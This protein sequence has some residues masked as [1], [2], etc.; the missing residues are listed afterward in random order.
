MNLTLFKLFVIFGTGGIFFYIG[1][2]HSE[3]WVNKITGFCTSNVET[4]V[5]ELDYM[6]IE[7]TTK[8]VW[9][10]L[11]GQHIFFILLFTGLVATTVSWPFLLIGIPIGAAFGL[12]F[13]K[14]PAVFIRVLRKR[15]VTAFTG[16]MIDGLTLMANAMRSGLNTPQTLQLV[17]D[18]MPNPIAQEF[19]LVLSQNKV[20]TPLEEAF[21]NLAQ[22]IPSDEVEM[23]STSITILKET[24]GN[25][26]ETFDTIVSTIQSRL[27]LE[28]KIGA[29]V[30]QGLMQGI[31]IFCI[32]FVLG[33]V[34]YFMEP[35][36][37]KLMFT[38]PIGWVIIFVMLCMQLIG[39]FAILKIIDVKV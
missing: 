9:K 37:M 1:K 30:A 32:P 13:W 29:M 17:A 4:I 26:A 39:G 33:I 3:G 10:I 11:I 5:S 31:I 35:E 36:K 23:F 24:G 15:R 25:L 12:F 28:N 14:F 16:Q 7:V 27:K 8:R 20:G 6:F 18:E 2:K 38:T 34:F 22:R 19:E 21:A